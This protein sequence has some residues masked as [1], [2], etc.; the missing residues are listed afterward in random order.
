MIK[1]FSVFLENR[2]GRLANLVNLLDKNGIKIMAMGIAEAGNYGI[3][4]CVLDNDAKALAILK[5]A[6]TAVN[7]V[8][9]LM[10]NLAQLETIVTVLEKA[11]VN[12]DYAYTMNSGKIIV[13][14]NDE[15]KAIKALNSAK[16]EISS[17]I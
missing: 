16:L 2:P 8:D 1:Q 3:V 12:I 6:N 9:V 10:L 14:V 15:E 4:R 17:K 7:V 5:D 13:K 11:G